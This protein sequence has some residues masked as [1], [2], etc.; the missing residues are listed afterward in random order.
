MMESLLQLSTELIIGFFALL[1]LTKI[2]GK[3]QITQ[4]TPFDFISALVLGELVGNAI[5]DH[6][7]RI[8]EI[9]YAI[10]L[11]G[12]LIFLVEQVTLKV[13][14][15]RAVFESHPSILIRDGVI[16]RKEMKDNRLDINQLQNL[17]RQQNVFSIRE[18]AYAILEP[19]GSLSVMKKSLF[20]QPTKADFSFP[21]EADTLPVTLIS[22]GKVVER[23]LKTANKTKQWL[24]EQLQERNLTDV[25]EVFYAEWHEKDGLFVQAYANGKRT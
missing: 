17:L 20:R 11:W 3:T 24:L 6:N 18:V 5:Y 7:I 12:L 4:A 14:R 13:N 25:N 21:A 9:L 1:V 8:W 16:D 2:V 19:N 10:A 15:W 23:N 22:D